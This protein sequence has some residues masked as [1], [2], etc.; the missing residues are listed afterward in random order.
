MVNFDQLLLAVFSIF[1]C[2]GWIP[3]FSITWISQ[4]LSL[5]V[6][7]LAKYEHDSMDLTDSKPAMF[8]TEK[9]MTRTFETLRVDCHIFIIE[10]PISRRK[11]IFILRQG[12]GSYWRR[13][14]CLVLRST[15]SGLNK[16]A[17]FL[18]KPFQFFLKML[19]SLFKLNWN[20]LF[21]VPLVISWLWFGYWLDTDQATNWKR[22]IPS[23]LMDMYMLLNGFGQIDSYNDLSSVSCHVVT[24]TKCCLNDYWVIIRNS[25]PCIKTQTLSLKKIHLKIFISKM[26]AILSWPQCVNSFA[27][28]RFEWNFK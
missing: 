6:A 3:I 17:R 22:W 24:H 18:R 1:R 28:G 20:W 21:G 19:V 9:L 16:M 8:P 4:L 10:I 27:P 7:T 14:H 12:P 13:H 25:E 26:T 23:S 5:A 11:T 15:H 2:G